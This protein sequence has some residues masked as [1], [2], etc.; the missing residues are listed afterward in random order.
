MRCITGSKNVSALLMH[1]NLL[2]GPFT[3]FHTGLFAT[4]DPVRS[5]QTFSVTWTPAS[6]TATSETK[7]VVRKWVMVR[8]PLLQEMYA[9]KAKRDCDFD[10]GYAGFKKM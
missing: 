2:S 1:A 9:Q 10:H 8:T 4:A 5:S 6:K 3:G 7:V